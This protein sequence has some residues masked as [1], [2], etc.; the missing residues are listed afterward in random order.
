MA[1]INLLPWREALRKERQN[2]FYGVIGTVLV[3]AA[4]IVYVVNVSVEGA[5]DS[6]RL[7]NDFIVK[8]T[9]VIDAKID[10]I[11]A[12]KE[13]RQ[14][15][16]ERM[17]LIQ[18]LQGNRPIIVRVFDE[19]ARSVPD[20]LYF[21][22]VSVKGTD[23][24]IKGVAKSNNRVAALMRNFDQSDWF[25]EPALIKVQSKSEGVNEFEVSMKR[26]QPKAEEE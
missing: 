4:A 17:E 25:A 23:V 8:E 21:S 22:S 5:I 16:I 9:K 19:M 18:A 7:R 2:Q 12:L 6:Q 24:M 26:V 10:E 14:K 3:V 11:K 1:K 20:D 13:T 15:L